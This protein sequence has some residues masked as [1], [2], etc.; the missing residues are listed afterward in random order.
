MVKIIFQY[1]KNM[2]KKARIRKKQ[3][4]YVHGFFHQNLR[5]I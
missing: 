3:N 2:I 4:G 1:I 5:K